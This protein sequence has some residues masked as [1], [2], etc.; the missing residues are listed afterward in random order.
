MLML[1]SGVEQ[2]HESDFFDESTDEIDEFLNKVNIP[3][4]KKGQGMMLWQSVK[5]I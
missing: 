3:K 5:I 1:Q 2:F 4:L